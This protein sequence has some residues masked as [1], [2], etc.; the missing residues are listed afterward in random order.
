MS[1]RVAV[2]TTPKVY[3]EE[4]LST[5]VLATTILSAMSLMKATRGETTALNLESVFT[6]AAGSCVLAANAVK[7][8]SWAT[9]DPYLDTVEVSTPTPAKLAVRVFSV[10]PLAAASSG[11]PMMGCPIRKMSLTA[12]VYV[13]AGLLMV[14]V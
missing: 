8:C 13:I 9:M 2:D 5:R 10:R 4:T 12:F 7:I 14:T 1:P 11:S 3:P 6:G